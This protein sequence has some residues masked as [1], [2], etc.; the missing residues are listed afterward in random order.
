M[1]ILNKVLDKSVVEQK[2]ELFLY[3]LVL[4]KKDPQP[5]GL[6]QKVYCDC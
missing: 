5:L 6:K 2:L 1:D 3:I 4:N